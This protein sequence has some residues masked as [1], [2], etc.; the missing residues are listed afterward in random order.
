MQLFWRV[1]FVPFGFA[2]LLLFIDLQVVSLYFFGLSLLS[3]L[4]SLGL[5]F[6]KLAFL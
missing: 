5:S 6:W 3:L 2:M 4:T 1:L